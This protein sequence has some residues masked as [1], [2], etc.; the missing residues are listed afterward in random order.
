MKT[1]E[2]RTTFSYQ[3]KRYE[4]RADSV[5]ELYMKKADKL[6]AL[7]EGSVTYDSHIL[8]D[9]WAEKAFDTYKANVTG[10]PDMKRRYWS[11][12][13]PYIGRKP[14][15]QV[16]AVECQAILNECKGKSFSHCNKLKQELSFIFEKA[17]DN[18]MIPMNPAK[19]I[20]LP[21]CSKGVRRSVTDEER[22]SF[23]RVYEKDPT[24]V[25]FLI[26]LECGLRPEEVAG[27]IG[28]DIDHE[29]KVLHVRGT[30]SK[31]SD[32]YVP[33]PESLYDTIKGTAPAAAIAL[34]RAGRKHSESSYNRMSEHLRRDM[35]IDMG[36]KM[37][38]N[39]L[40][41]PYPLAEDFVPYCFRHTYCTDLCRAGVDIRTAQKLM[42]HAD[43][44]ITANIYT[45]VDIDIVK[46]AGKIIEDY[47]KKI[48]GAT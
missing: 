37:Y 47:Q 46:N 1:Y 2:H 45:H 18:Q 36:C 8:V 9:V 11:Y 22:Q 12:V 28:S 13:S 20:K 5:E 4:V 19:K 3:G 32:R 17:V 24:Y 26:M 44:S 25:F 6:R 43:I 23:Y 30:K 7:K 42:G 33:I 27:L 35:N 39:R 34:N 10:L 15:G 21:E 48:K 31:N 14:I 38:R 40:I 16:R 29:Q 41:P